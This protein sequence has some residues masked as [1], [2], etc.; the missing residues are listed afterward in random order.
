MTRSLNTIL[1]VEDDPTDALLLRKA[2]SSRAR[3]CRLQ[4]AADGEQ[5]IEYLSGAGDFA[6]RLE[7]PLPQI[8]LLDLRL[9]RAS[10]FD[11]LA[12]V[13]AQ[14]RLRKL[15]VIVLSSS[16]APADMQRAYA[17]GANSYLVKPSTYGQLAAL[18]SDIEAYWMK[19]N[20]RPLLDG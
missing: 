17:A 18:V 16:D 7:H 8:V 14:P 1:L 15:P 13:K 11:V 4:H 3:N 12:W 20:E 6:D 19:L 5:A 9:P 10:G 2:V